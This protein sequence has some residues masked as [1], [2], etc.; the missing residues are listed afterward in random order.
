MS[1]GIHW[2]DQDGQ[3]QFSA[4]FYADLLSDL[5]AT[6]VLG[7]GPTAHDPQPFLDAGMETE[8]LAS[9]EEGARDGVLTLQALDRFITLVDGA[10][11]LVAVHCAGRLPDACTLLSAYMLRRRYFADPVQAVSW[12]AMACPGSGVRVRPVLLESIAAGGAGPGLQALLARSSSHGDELCSLSTLD[13][14]EA[15]EAAEASEAGPANFR[16]GGEGPGPGSRGC[17]SGAAVA[18]PARHVAQSRR[19]MLLSSSS[20]ILVT[21]HGPRS[22]RCARACAWSSARVRKRLFLLVHPLVRPFTWR[23][24]STPAFDQR[25]GVDL[26]FGDRPA[27]RRFDQRSGIYPVLRRLTS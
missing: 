19:A 2:V 20:P 17:G 13:L 4:T 16:R 9:G 7:I 10:D 8:L 3:R 22:G 15:A 5:G 14:G 12:L 21:S 11:G 27:I 6:L 24:T 25:T 26:R 23:L 1:D 18:D